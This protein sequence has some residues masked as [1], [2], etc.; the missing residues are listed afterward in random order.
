MRRPTVRAVTILLAA[1]LA[2]LPLA[3]MA[4]AADEPPR[5]LDVVE[6]TATSSDGNIPENVLDGDLAT[7][8]SAQTLDVDDPEHLTLDLGSVQRV[9][10]LGVAWHQ[11]DQRQALFGIA[12]S[13]DGS[14]W[15]VLADDRASSG[16]SVDLEAVAL[17]GVDP[18]DG[19]DARYVRY[20]GYGNTASGWNSVTEA[21]VYAPHPDGAVV[22]ELAG[23]APQ[24]DPDAEPYTAPGLTEPDG[25]PRPILAPAPTTGRTLDV[26]DFGADPADDGGD[27]APAL[28]A[29]LE[30]AVAGDEV[31]LPAGTYDLVS[32]MPS[33]R[34]ANLALRSG[35][36]LRGAGAGETILRSHLSSGD[37]AGKVLRG[38]GV[39][40]VE[41][42]GVTVTST[43][44]G[45]FSTDHQ[46]DDAGGGPQYGIFLTDAASRPSERILITDVVVERFERMGVRVEN[47][48]DVVVERAT[49]RDATG[50]GGGGQG[51][52]VSIQGIAKTD[53]L[54]FPN[55]SR[56]NVVRNS[57]FVGPHLRHGVLLQFFTHNNLVA[58][59]V[60]TEI[61]LDAIDLHGEDEYLNE[62]RGN[63]IR[64][65]AAAAIALG[66]T[67]GSPPSNHD[68]AG[69]GNWIHRNTISGNREGIK[70]HMGSPDTLIERN[71][72]TATSRPDRAD[73]IL[74]LN[75]PGTV[76]RDN[77][78]SGN[79]APGFWGIRLAVDP[80]DRN[81]D[82]VG[83]GIPTDV[84]ITGNRI[85]GNT[86]GLWVA[87]GEDLTIAD[88]VIRGNGEDVRITEA[89]APDPEPEP[90]PT[91]EVL[92]PTDDT[93]IDNGAPDATAGAATLLKWKQNSS[94]SIQR[95]VWY[96]FEVD[97]SAQVGRA[98]LELSA[99]INETT[100]TSPPFT[101]EVH[102]VG[103]A[104]WSE[105]TLTWDT[106]T[107]TTLTPDSRVG[108][109]T[110]SGPPE[111]VQRFRI[112]VTDAVRAADG[113]A[114]TLVVG[115][116]SGQNVNVDSYSKERGDAS[117]RPTLVVNR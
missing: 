48:R 56:H 67:G 68:A 52:G 59:N 108:T 21:R 32:T 39:A 81:A 40:D 16:T 95:L 51:Y 50:V 98:H 4:A 113:G 53:R 112:D 102:A 8:W 70:V 71:T 101:F 89:P 104:G 37:G 18:R 46:A 87:A 29:A 30:A 97:E 26:T 13:S 90:D 83:A 42:S 115:D 105:D 91:A 34:S 76:V 92:L 20:L 54:G 61:V 103:D 25:S 65:G 117:L 86:G 64:D 72:I 12:V 80:G 36:S 24:P 109:F 33:D 47:S 78:I 82:D 1:L 9:G 85:T 38:Y 31:V 5:P 10:Y 49:F 14:A 15:E 73:G 2:V 3:G 110:M 96:R 100:T 111:D 93:M 19:V 45:P 94:G 74:V 69:P 77:T 84:T 116:P 27:D 66:N 17:D 99:K 55:D 58:D 23:N 60:F 79:R 35:V 22:E 11:G 44:N 114:L 57:T 75:A 6:V 88:N 106:A 62:I 43:F 7:R 63:D 41:V 28:R 107:V